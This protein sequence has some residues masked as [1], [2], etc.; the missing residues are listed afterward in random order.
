MKIFKKAKNNTKDKN[1]NNNIKS[2]PKKKK[3]SKIKIRNKE[4]NNL[5][6]NKS[7]STFKKID[8]NKKSINLININND[9]KRNKDKSKTK[10]NKNIRNSL[11]KN[12]N[13]KIYKINYN[14]YEMNT[15]EYQD[16][17]KFDKRTYFQY[18]LSLLKTKHILLFSFVTNDYNSLI[19][20]IS[21]F[22]FSFA[23]YF[24]VNALFITDKTMH[25]IFV[26]KGK[27]I[28]R[29]QIKK[30]IYSNLISTAINLLMNILSLPEKKVITVKKNN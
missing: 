18:Y 11:I 20:K 22:F 26:D 27:Y 12:N 25:N 9:I 8:N 4:N 23:L 28:F 5:N 17:L 14:D 1:N 7:S 15:L 16:A 30:I 24:T 13:R 10:N 19:I 21:L 6:N 29:N 3:Q 2:P